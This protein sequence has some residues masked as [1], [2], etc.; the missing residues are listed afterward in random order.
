MGDFVINESLQNAFVRSNV[1][2][3]AIRIFISHSPSRTALD[4]LWL[5][6]LR[7]YAIIQVQGL[8]VARQPQLS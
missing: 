3:Y 1:A 2:F 6:F 7:E 4:Y 5:Y 8:Y